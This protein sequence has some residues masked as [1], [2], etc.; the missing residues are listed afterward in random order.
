MKNEDDILPRRRRIVTSKNM[1]R[2]KVDTK[3]HFVTPKTG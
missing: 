2:N 3:I 1:I